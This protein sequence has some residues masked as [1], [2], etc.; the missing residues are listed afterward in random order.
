[1]TAVFIIENQNDLQLL[2]KGSVSI[3]NSSMNVCFTSRVGSPEQQKQ[4]KQVWPGV[5]IMAAEIQDN[6]VS[7][8]AMPMYGAAGAMN[9]RQ[10]NMHGYAG[11]ATDRIV[12]KSPALMAKEH[13]HIT[14]REEEILE[15]LSKGLSYNE[16]ANRLFISIKTLKKHIYNIYEKLDVDNKIK[17]VNKFYGH[18]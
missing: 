13:Y 2:L 18:R 15:Q 5:E 11:D 7:F 12:I 9:P 3:D 6:K 4:L 8:G 14:N 1:M 10:V 16:I 17:A